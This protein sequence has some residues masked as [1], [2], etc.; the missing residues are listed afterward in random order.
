ME[1]GAR[2]DAASRQLLGQMCHMLVAM[3]E[4]L[5]RRVCAEVLGKQGA[6]VVDDHEHR[7]AVTRNGRDVIERLRLWWVV[8]HHP[9]EQVRG[10]GREPSQSGVV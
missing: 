3:S 10:R 5:G 4:Q 8:R 1:H 2:G 6:L 7:S 9:D